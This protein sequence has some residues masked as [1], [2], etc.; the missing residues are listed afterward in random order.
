MVSPPP[1]V[2]ESRAE[3][4]R[5]AARVIVAAVRCW[6]RRPFGRQAARGL[7]GRAGSGQDEKER[8][9]E[10]RREKAGEEGGQRR[11]APARGG[12]SAIAITK[13][14]HSHPPEDSA[15]KHCVPLQ[16]S[17]GSAGSKCDAFG[18]LVFSGNTKTT[19]IITSQQPGLCPSRL[20]FS[21]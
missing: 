8:E 18:K 2:M 14:M 7:P 5:T 12:G 1:T 15:I 21:S 11:C 4:R 17:S 19:E 6:L 10:R 3:Q 20:Q 13:A 16:D 9:T